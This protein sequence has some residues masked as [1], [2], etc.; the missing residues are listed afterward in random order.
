MTATPTAFII[1]TS[2]SDSPNGILEIPKFKLGRARFRVIHV[3]VTPNNRHRE[4]VRH[5]RSTSPRP[6]IQAQGHLR[7]ASAQFFPFDS[8]PCTDTSVGSI[9]CSRAGISR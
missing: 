4:L 6:D 3:R 5:V 8:D 9:E 7:S 2:E 1:A